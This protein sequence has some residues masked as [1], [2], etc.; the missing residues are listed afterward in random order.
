MKNKTIEKLGIG[1]I[2]FEGLEHI[3]N[4]I[5]NFKFA[6][7]KTGISSYYIVLF[8][9]KYDYFQRTKIA[10]D[11]IELALKLKELDFID[12]VMFFMY[13]SK[14]RT[15]DIELEKRNTLLN[16]LNDNGCSHNIIID[17]DEFYTKD[18]LVKSMNYIIEN[19]PDITYCQYLNYINEEN[20]LLYKYAEGMYVPFITRKGFSFG[21]PTVYS[22]VVNLPSDE[23][24]RYIYDKNKDSLHI[25]PFEDIHMKHM[26][27]MRIDLH[28]K[29]KVWSSQHCVDNYEEKVNDMIKEVENFDYEKWKGKSLDFYFLG[30]GLKVY[31]CSNEF[32]FEYDWRNI[33]K[34]L[35][36]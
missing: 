9:Q 5:S 28:K 4:I 1:I 16:I 26:N 14:K 32:D 35:N 6:M 36:I 31:N 19:N 30:P 13:D 2:A 23:T 20:I 29:F 24:R 22:S 21:L 27:L 15:N 3:P 34:E 18:S 8:L 7:Q 33:N 17:S 25:F 10:E 11:D 12:D